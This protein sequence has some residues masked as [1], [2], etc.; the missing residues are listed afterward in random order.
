[1]TFYFVF[2]GTVGALALVLVGVV[3]RDYRKDVLRGHT[4]LGFGSYVLR[5]G[6]KAVLKAILQFVADMLSGLL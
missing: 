2:F 6:V 3:Y 5:G 4:Q 1:M